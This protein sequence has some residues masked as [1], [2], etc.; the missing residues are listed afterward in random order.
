MVAVVLGWFG[1]GTG[2]PHYQGSLSAY[3]RKLKD[4][5]LELEQYEYSGLGG[6]EK[7]HELANTVEVGGE[8]KRAFQPWGG[9]KR[10]FQPWG[11]KRS[12]V[13]D[14]EYVN[15]LEKRYFSGWGYDKP[16]S[17]VL[18][19]LIKKGFQPWGGKRTAFQPWGGKRSAP[20][21]SALESEHSLDTHEL[22]SVKRDFDALVESQEDKRA[23]QPWGGK[24]AFQPW[25]GKRVFQP[26]G[27]KRAFQ[28]WG[29]KRAFQP[30]GGK[31][32]FQPWGGKRSVEGEVSSS[33][34]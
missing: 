34:S 23:F 16:S 28:P 4:L 30:W 18:K 31:R 29:G 22:D 17:D 15:G 11:G 14:G 20:D 7:V 26:W 19:A 8:E 24:R 9:K 1:E 25:G 21:T 12:G 10:A 32:K 13:D 3:E 6:E 2:S 5:L 27:G 33:S